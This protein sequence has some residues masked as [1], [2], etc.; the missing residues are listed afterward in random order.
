MRKKI[1]VILVYKNETTFKKLCSFQQDNEI[2]KILFQEIFK[3]IASKAENNESFKENI[4]NSIKHIFNSST[5]FN[6]HVISAMLDILLKNKNKIRMDPQLIA[7]VCQE[8]GL[9]SIGALLLEDY[10]YSSDVQPSTSKKGS[11]CEQDITISYW[12]KLAE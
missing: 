9:I 2:S 11:G 4:S 5:S 12:V 6:P 1:L 3:G 7:Y 10:I 8:S